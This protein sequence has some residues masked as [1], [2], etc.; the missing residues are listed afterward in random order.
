[1]KVKDL[2]SLL[3]EDYDKDDEIYVAWWARDHFVSTYKASVL[4]KP[5][6]HEVVERLERNNLDDETYAI[7]EVIDEVVS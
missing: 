6:W 5:R 7:M 2:I 4:T 3:K 1:M